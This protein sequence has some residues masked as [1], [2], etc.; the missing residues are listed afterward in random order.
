MTLDKENSP[1]FNYLENREAYQK[2]FG[3]KMRDSFFPTTFVRIIFL[4][5]KYLTS[6]RQDACR[7]T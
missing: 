1:L 6:Y 5:D 4:S 7:N 3:H 2:H